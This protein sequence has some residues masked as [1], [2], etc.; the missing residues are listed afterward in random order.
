MPILNKQPTEYV[1]RMS[2]SRDTLLGILVIAA[3]V[4]VAMGLHLA[5][6]QSVGGF[7]FSTWG[8]LVGTGLVVIALAHATWSVYVG[9]LAHSDPRARTDQ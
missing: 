7:T 1:D 8:F 3:V 2:R 9:P 6:L 5:N 4:T